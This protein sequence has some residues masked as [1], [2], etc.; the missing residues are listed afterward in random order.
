[1]NFGQN[2]Q[3][4]QNGPWYQAYANNPQPDDKRSQPMATAAIILS[5]V[6]VS[7]I[8]CIYISIPCGSLGIVFAL[9]S[10][11]GETTMS[12]GARTAVWVSV[13][14]MVLTLFLLAG[15][16]AM[17]LMQYGSIEAFLKAYMEMIEAYSGAL[18]K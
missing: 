15:S 14:A 13:M 9:L 16:L 2:Q 3:D 6:A 7:T 5:V 12:V 17:L 11:G 8:C 1:M 18:P 10:K 4:F